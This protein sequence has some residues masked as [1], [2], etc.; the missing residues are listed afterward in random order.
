VATYALIDV[1]RVSKIL[2]A[3]QMWPKI[4]AVRRSTRGRRGQSA[5]EIELQSPGWDYFSSR[6]TRIHCS[7]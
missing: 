6:V 4:H 5:K 1:M 2:G 3:T 7:I